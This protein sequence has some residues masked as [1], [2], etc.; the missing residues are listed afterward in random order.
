MFKEHSYQTLDDLKNILFYHHDFMEY[1]I[2][3]SLYTTRKMN[4]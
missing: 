4:F 1:Y 3:E 2:S